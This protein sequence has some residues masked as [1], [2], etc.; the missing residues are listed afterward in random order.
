[1][2][3]IKAAFESLKRLGFAAI[4]ANFV[5]IQDMAG[6]P[7]AALNPIRLFTI[8]NRTDQDLFFS[9]DGINPFLLIPSSE[10]YTVDLCSNQSIVAGGFELPEGTRLY[11]K[12]NLAA[13]TAGAIYWTIC[14]GSE[15]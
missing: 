10:S 5:G 9:F 12:Q 1:M 2:K 4:G 14:Y 8:L 6:N 13:P 7:A 11:V 15:Q 3:E